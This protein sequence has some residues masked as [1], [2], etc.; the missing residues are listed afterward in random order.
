M[1]ERNGNATL[2]IGQYTFAIEKYGK[3][4]LH[5]ECI[6]ENEDRYKFKKAIFSGKDSHDKKFNIAFS[7][8]PKECS[9][10]LSELKYVTPLLNSDSKDKGIEISDTATET[11]SAAMPSYLQA[12]MSCFCLDWNGKI[13][14]WKLSPKVSGDLLLESILAFEKQV[15]AK[16]DLEYSN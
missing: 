6:K 13:E 4:L 2:A 11:V 7:A 15:S 12:R 3:S 14:K 16:L 10:F 5:K 1:L 9:S 8:L